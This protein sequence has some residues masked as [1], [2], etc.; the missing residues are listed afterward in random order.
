M[1]PRNGIFTSKYSLEPSIAHDPSDQK[2]EYHH[3]D[4][5]DGGRTR[6]HNSLCT[7]SLC[8]CARSVEVQRLALTSGSDDA[9][10]IYQ[11]WSIDMGRGHQ[12]LAE[13][14][15]PR[16]TIGIRGRNAPGYRQ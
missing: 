14:I 4:G 15:L 8:P 2:G 10:P 5:Y 6:D 7:I 12:T 1:E 11:R 16:G 13:T 9:T 3:S